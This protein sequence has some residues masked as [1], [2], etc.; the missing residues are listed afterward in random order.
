LF[1]IGKRYVTTDFDLAL[2]RANEILISAH[3][4]PREV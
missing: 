1:Q 2:Q 3:K 4:H